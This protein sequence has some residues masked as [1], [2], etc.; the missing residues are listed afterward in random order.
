M[1]EI[2]IPIIIVFLIIL[3]FVIRENLLHKKILNGVWI[4][5]D[6]FVVESDT[7][8]FIMVI[9]TKDKKPSIAITVSM[10]DEEIENSLCDVNISQ[11][12]SSYFSDVKE[13]TVTGYDDG[14]LPNIFRMKLDIVA[15]LLVIEKG[16][17]V[18]AVLAK[19]NN[20]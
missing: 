13:Y 2:L 9:D 10:D 3:I 7:D 16:N 18:Y 8:S 5:T 6:E 1:Y 19:E 17:I 15:G 12:P 11:D 20:I 14:F 4:G